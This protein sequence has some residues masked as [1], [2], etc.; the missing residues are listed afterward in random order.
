MAQKTHID[1]IREAEAKAQEMITQAEKA[2]ARKI[3][4][5]RVQAEQDQEEFRQNI[6]QAQRKRMASQEQQLAAVS[7]EM[8]AQAQKDADELTQRVATRRKDVLATVVA[9]IIG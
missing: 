5:T 7:E 3:M 8:I 2:A 6:A 4:D 1:V 9:R